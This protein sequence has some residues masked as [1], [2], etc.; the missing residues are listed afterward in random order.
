MNP[1]SG[2]DVLDFEILDSQ[3][4]S[5]SSCALSPTDIIVLPLT[6]Q[7]LKQHDEIFD[8]K[9]HKRKAA[10]KQKQRLGMDGLGLSSF[11][12]NH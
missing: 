11:T 2:G 10:K 3:N 12:V 1:Q 8:P 4:D 6:V 5:S 9:K 7:N